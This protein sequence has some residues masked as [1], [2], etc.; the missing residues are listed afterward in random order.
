MNVLG[1]DTTTGV[2][3]LILNKGEETISVSASS[4]LAHGENLFPWLEQILEKAALEPKD[5]ELIVCALGPGSFTGLRI[6]LAAAKGLALSA[7]CPLTGVPTLDI[8]GSR[9]RFFPG[10]VVPVIDA[11]KGRF[12]AA[13]YNGG[14]RT[15][16]FLDILPDDFRTMLAELKNVLLTGPNAAMIYTDGTS[17]PRPDHVAIL[18]SSQELPT[19]LELGI[20]TFRESGPLADGAGPLYVRPSEAEAVRA[21]DKNG[22]HSPQSPE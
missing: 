4:G 2:L 8:Y 6:G 7:G 9:Y 13:C 17:V 15:G 3:G 20:K 16:D 11:R 18:P 21:Q 22:D 1:I 19:L 12:Y 5:L 14:R 10:T